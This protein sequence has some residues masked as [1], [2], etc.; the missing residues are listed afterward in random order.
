MAP[1]LPA[2]VSAINCHTFASSFR[3]Y[4]AKPTGEVKVDVVARDRYLEKAEKAV[5]VPQK[6]AQ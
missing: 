2:D 1:P 5:K 4:N 6:G 3:P